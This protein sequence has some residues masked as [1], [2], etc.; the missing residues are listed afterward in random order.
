MAALIARA[1]PAGPGTPPT[2]LV[3]PACL[4]AGSWD[5]EDWGN[6]FQDQNGLDANLW[7]NVGTLAFYGVA[8]GY[9]DGTFGPNDKVSYIQS[10]SFITRAMVAKGYWLAQPNETVPYTGIPAAHLADV[11]TFHFYTKGAFGG[12]PDGFN[13]WN[14]ASSRGW[15]ARALW[16]ALDS[17]FGGGSQR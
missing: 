8:Y 3:P 9:G 13:D 11:R 2:T 16:A 5:C 6:G 12:V 10:V 7:R 15:F 17:Q 14:S 1:T 4:V